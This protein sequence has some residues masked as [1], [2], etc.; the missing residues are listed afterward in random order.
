MRCPVCARWFD[1]GQRREFLRIWDEAK[2]RAAR[3]QVELMAKRFDAA[4]AE[5]DT[6]FDFLSRQDVCCDL[7]DRELEE[8]ENAMLDRQAG[9]AIYRLEKFIHPSEA[10]AS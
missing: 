3:I 2:T 7:V 10:V 8:A 9:E 6:L 5:L 1:Y 4:M